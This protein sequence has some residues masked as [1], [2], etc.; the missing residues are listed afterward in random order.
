MEPQGLRSSGDEV[1]IGRWR[2]EMSSSDKGRP[3]R[4]ILF[5]SLSFVWVN[6]NLSATR[7]EIDDT[8]HFLMSL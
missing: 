8:Y 5:K 3:H 1:Y 2:E 4:H 6:T 7:M